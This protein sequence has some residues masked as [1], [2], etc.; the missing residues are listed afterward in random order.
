MLF[1]LNRVREFHHGNAEG[2]D[3]EADRITR[4]FKVRPTIKKH[5]AGRDPLKRDRK[6]VAIVDVLIAAPKTDKE[7]LRSGTWA[8]IR[9]ARKKSIP[10]ITLP[11]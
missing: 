8:T 3:K 4:L 9:Y 7:V 11:R 1:L 6:I 5:P 2:A 10:I